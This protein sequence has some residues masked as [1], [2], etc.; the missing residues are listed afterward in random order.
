V[1]LFALAR[2]RT[3][4][5]ELFLDHDRA[6]QALKEVPADERAADEMAVVRIKLPGTEPKVERLRG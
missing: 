6:E 5:A 2:S 3:R 1:E 4:L